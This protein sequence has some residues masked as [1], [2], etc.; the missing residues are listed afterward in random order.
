MAAL[1]TRDLPLPANRPVEV[2]MMEV[3]ATSCLNTGS[4]FAIVLRAAGWK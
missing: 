1:I 4:H 2:E 3:L